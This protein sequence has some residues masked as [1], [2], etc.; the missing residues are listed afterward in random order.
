MD[1]RPGQSWEF[2]QPLPE[3]GIGL[4]KPWAPCECNT[5]MCILHLHWQ[6]IPPKPLWAPWAPSNT[7]HT[8]I[9]GQI[10]A[11]FTDHMENVHSGVS[12]TQPQSS[13]AVSHGPCAAPH[14]LFCLPEGQAQLP[15]SQNGQ[16]Y[17]QEG[18]TNNQ[19]LDFHNT[20]SN[21]PRK[22]NLTVQNAW[23]HSV[24]K[25]LNMGRSLPPK[26]G[27]DTSRNYHRSPNS[28]F[29]F[30]LLL[31][32]FATA[33]EYSGPSKNAHKTPRLCSTGLLRLDS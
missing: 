8:H 27:L 26:N 33:G 14:P 4:S 19:Q 28:L 32:F 13:L 2:K 3:L 22:W 9:L 15:A 5:K 10:A 30:F 17:V 1:E 11:V 12:T 21:T 18:G 23:E 31:A 7:Q 16:S 29:F 25:V 20:E 6:Q 24:S